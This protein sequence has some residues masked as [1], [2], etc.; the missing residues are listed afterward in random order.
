MGPNP[1]T[2]PKPTQYKWNPIKITNKI[3]PLQV[4][5]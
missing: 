3:I 1:A 4:G 2:L 5:S